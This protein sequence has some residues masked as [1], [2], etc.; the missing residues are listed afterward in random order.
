MLIKFWFVVF[1]Q[2]APSS[3]KLKITQLTFAACIHCGLVTCKFSSSNVIF[4]LTH[5]SR[6]YLVRINFPFVR[7]AQTGKLSDQRF[8]FAFDFSVFSPFVHLPSLIARFP[9]TLRRLLIIVSRQPEQRRKW[10]SLKICEPQNRC[11]R[12]R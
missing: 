6:D 5:P 12:F 8:S 2:A 3:N 10:F 11:V 7:F 9:S 4:I 1:L